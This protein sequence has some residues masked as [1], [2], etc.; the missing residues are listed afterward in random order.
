MATIAELEKRLQ[1]AEPGATH[2]FEVLFSATGFARTDLHA[3]IVA[4][5]SLNSSA[6]TP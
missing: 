6:A 2:A 3:D 1:A 5:H 4:I